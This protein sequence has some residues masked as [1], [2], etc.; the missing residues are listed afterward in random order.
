MLCYHTNS[1]ASSRIL[2]GGYRCSKERSCGQ[3]TSNLAS[4]FAKKG[5]MAGGIILVSTDIVIVVLGSSLV[6]LGM[7]NIVLQSY[8]FLTYQ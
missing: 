7:T 2:G 6:L 4:L 3:R 8:H 5:C 1:Y